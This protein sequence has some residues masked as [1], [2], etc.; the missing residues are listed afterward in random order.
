VSAVPLGASDADYLTMVFTGARNDNGAAPFGTYAAPRQ[1]TSTRNHVAPNFT[2]QDT[3]GQGLVFSV[4]MGKGNVGTW[5]AAPTGWTAGVVSVQ[6]NSYM[7]TLDDRKSAD[8]AAPTATTSN[9][10]YDFAHTLEILPAPPI[11]VPSPGSAVWL[12]DRRVWPPGDLPHQVTVLRPFP[13]IPVN[14]FAVQWYAPPGVSGVDIVMLGGGGGGEQAGLLADG[15]GGGAGAWKAISLVSDGN[16]GGDN[17]W[18]ATLPIIIV[19]GTG[20]RGGLEFSNNCDDGIGGGVVWNYDAESEDS[21]I[22]WLLGDNSTASSGDRNGVSVAPFTFNG[23]TY[24]GG[25]GGNGT[26]TPGA[27]GQVPGGG[28]QG[29]KPAAWGAGYGGSGADGAVYLWVY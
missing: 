3:S 10:I 1:A 20:G 12:G 27:N 23:R 29:G 7:A 16:A 11:K 19:P 5:G 9:A 25:A 2:R 17:S 14:D 18:D 26:A 4:W 22:S 6:W 24:L 21:G 28:G 8:F 13:N 15:K